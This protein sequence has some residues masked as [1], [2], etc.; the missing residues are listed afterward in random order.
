MPILSTD[1]PPPG[2]VRIAAVTPDSV[3][4][5]WVNPVGQSGQPRFRVSWRCRLDNQ[6]RFIYVKSTGVQIQRLISG[7]E[8]EFKVA[9]F[10]KDGGQSLGVS[11]TAS[12]GTVSLCIK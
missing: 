7:E 8:Y 3:T 4:L 10:S 9:T 6:R 1:I 5:K 12:T 11:I 2:Q